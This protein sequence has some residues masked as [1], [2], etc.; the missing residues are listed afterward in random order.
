MKLRE[1]KEALDRATAPMLEQEAVGCFVQAPGEL[2]LILKPQPG[3][4]SQ[5]YLYGG[6]R[7]PAWE[8]VNDQ[9]PFEE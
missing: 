1:M 3:A 5:A 8:P 4:D 7:G 2:G 6:P 9:A